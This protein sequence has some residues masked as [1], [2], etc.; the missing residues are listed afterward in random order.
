MTGRIAGNPQR[1]YARI[2]GFMYLFLIVIGLT[3][4]AITS[5]IEVGG[6]VVEISRSVAASERLY[7]I[8]LGLGLAE[9]LCALLLAVSLYVTVKP[10]DSNLATMALLFRLVEVV[11]GALAS[12]MGFA[13]LQLYIDAHG[14]SAFDT[15]QW[16]A[17][18]D[19]SS[20]AGGASS[21]VS[22]ISFSVG[23][24]IFFS[25]F[26]RSGYIPRILSVLGIFGSLVFAAVGVANLVL[27]QY[28]SV[29]SVGYAPI[30]VAEISTGLWLL[31]RGVKVRPGDAPDAAE[32]VR[33]TSAA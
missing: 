1:I 13:T 9:S 4:L 14:A 22:I 11:T 6:T 21:S 33:A 24:T 18:V 17:L 16:S 25:L 3:S 20:A 29:A 23:S 12:V 5:R 2:A 28:S 10:V 32:P 8:G 15:S 27:P 7:R 30:A 31:I 19:L 26:L